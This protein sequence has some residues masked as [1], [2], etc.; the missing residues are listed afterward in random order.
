MNWPTTGN[1]PPR[2]AYLSMTILSVSVPPLAPSIR[3][4]FPSAG[5]PRGALALPV[6]G[7]VLA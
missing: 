3:I 7:S 5:N 6:G 2:A 1:P 4:L